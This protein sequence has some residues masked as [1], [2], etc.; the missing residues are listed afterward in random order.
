[1]MSV[2]ATYNGKNYLLTKG[3]D[4]AVAERSING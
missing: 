3:A 1:M 2:I 4:N